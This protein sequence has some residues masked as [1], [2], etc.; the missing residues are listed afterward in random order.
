MPA[1][2]ESPSR[3]FQN[4]FHHEGVIH[5]MFRVLLLLTLLST[6]PSAASPNDPPQESSM[7]RVDAPEAGEPGRPPLPWPFNAQEA[8]RRQR[9]T[10]AQW[11]IPVERTIRLRHDVEMHFVLIP[12]G[13]FVMGSPE[14]EPGRLPERGESQRRV[15]ISRPFYMAKYPCTQ[16]Q[17][18]AL[19]DSNPSRFHALDPDIP[20]DMTSWTC[21]T[22]GFLPRIQPDAPEGMRFALPTEAQWEYAARAGTATAFSFGNTLTREHANVDNPRQQPTPVGRYPANAWGLHDMHGNVWEWCRDTFHADAYTVTP[23]VDPLD[24]RPS[25]YHVLRGGSWRG[26]PEDARSAIRGRSYTGRP[27]LYFGFRLILEFEDDAL[28]TPPASTLHE[29]PS[30]TAGASTPPPATPQEDASDDANLQHSDPTP[31]GNTP[32]KEPAE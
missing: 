19:I 23:A 3:I 18:S 17:W 29:G 16:R 11:G 15:T 2:D 14:T 24:E 22:K 30:D 9:E 5:S 1:T 25:R 7:V 21:V 27:Y 28:S 12:P 26:R 20:A 31:A 10:A 4:P 13:S 8:Q 32:R 6:H